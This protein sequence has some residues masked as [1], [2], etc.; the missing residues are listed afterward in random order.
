[1]HNHLLESICSELVRVMGPIAPVVMNDKIHDLGMKAEN[2][3]LD[4]IAQLV[5]VLS[6]E[7]QDDEGR[8]QFQKGA[9][10]ELKHCGV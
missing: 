6:Y 8:A 9:L 10:N 2:F 7:I 5:E 3:P 4:R 1:M